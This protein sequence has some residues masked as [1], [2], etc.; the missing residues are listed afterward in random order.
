M[1][2]GYAPLERQ[3]TAILFQLP[4]RWRAITAARAFPRSPPGVWSMP[5]SRRASQLN[6]GMHPGT[7]PET[8]DLLEPA[9]LGHGISRHGG[10]RRLAVEPGKAGGWQALPERPRVILPSIPL[11]YL[12]L[13]GTT[14]KYAGEYG[15]KRL[16]PWAMLASSALERNIPVHT[17]FNNTQAGAAVKDA[18]R[19]GA[20]LGQ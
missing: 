18:L 11:V 2:A 1:V 19:F 17:Y 4:P 20:M 12:R 7:P 10:L 9:W 13:H 3:L 6:S 8:L 14:G 5:P 15:Q 16:E